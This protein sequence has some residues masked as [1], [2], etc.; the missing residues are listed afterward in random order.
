MRFSVLVTVPPAP[1]VMAPVPVIEFPA[2][3]TML[4]PAATG[5]L[6]VRLSPVLPVPQVGPPDVRLISPP[7]T[8]PLVEKFAGETVVATVPIVNAPALAK[9]TRPVLVFAAKVLTLFASGRLILTYASA[10]S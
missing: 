5:L 8:T 1:G 10:A 9:L 3:R 7:A 6:I 4:P 2:F